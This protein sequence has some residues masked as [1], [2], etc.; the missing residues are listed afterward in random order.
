LDVSE[1]VAQEILQTTLRLLCA[2]HLQRF[3]SSHAKREVTLTGMVQ[4]QVRTGRVDLLLVEENEVLIV[5]F[6]SD[7]NPPKKVPQGYVEQLELYRALLAPL[8]PLLR[9][10]T[11]I[12]W[13]ST[14]ELVEANGGDASI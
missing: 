14:G 2:P 1:E 8:Y 6:K 10:T 9:V 12:L 13:T 11:W 4:G 5:D 3:F 7:Q